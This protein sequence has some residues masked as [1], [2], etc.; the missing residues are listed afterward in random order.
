MVGALRLETDLADG[1]ITSEGEA[2][3]GGDGLRGLT[4]PLGPPPAPG[5]AIQA[6]PGVLWLRLTI[7]IRV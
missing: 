7:R 1:V 6:A 5:E 4:H 2:E 3:T